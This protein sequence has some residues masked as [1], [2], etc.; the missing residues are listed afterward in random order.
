MR[1][2]RLLFGFL[3]ALVLVLGTGIAGAAEKAV[4]GYQ[5]DYER[6]VTIGRPLGQGVKDYVALWKKKTGGKIDGVEI[7]FSECDHGYNVD[8]GL[9]CYQRQK[10]EGIVTL[11][12]FGTPVTNALAPK[13]EEDKIPSISPGFGIA[14][15][16]DGRFPYLFPAAAN[17]WSQASAAIKYINDKEGSL[18]G[19][20]I[21]FLHMDVP[22]GREPIPILKKLSEKLGFTLKTF[23]VPVPGVEMG[24]QVTDITRRYR[25]DWVVA[26]LWGRAASVSFKELVRKGFPLDHYIGLKIGVAEA[27]V[28]AAGKDTSKGLQGIQ[29]FGLGHDFDILR[30]IKAMYKAKGKPMHKYW[31][32]TGY[33]NWG[34]LF[35]ALQIE[36]VRQAIKHYGTPVTGEKVKKGYEQIKNWSVGKLFPPLTFSKTDHEGGGWCRVYQW[37]G[38][39]FVMTRDWFKGYRD[40]IKE[41]LQETAKK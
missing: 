16:M 35:A 4:I 15:S 13:F 11:S 5:I 3:A 29:I 8:R 2:K 7:Q 17:Y 21:A 41:R 36:G 28:M 31:N 38:E 14:T 6:I 10:R 34:I 25:A 26:H 20:K 9:E 32:V 33:Y 27:D 23:G 1:E 18:K 30:D 37:D 19:K 40:V 39:K 12:M 24:A 22:G